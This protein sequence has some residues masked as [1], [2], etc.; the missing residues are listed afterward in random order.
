ML[1]ELSGENAEVAKDVAQHIAAFA[2]QFVT[3][4]EVPSRR[5]RQ[6]ARDRRGDRPRGGQARGA[7]AKIVEGR[8]N[9]FFK[10]TV[11]VEQAFAKDNKK[12][13]GKVLEEAGGRR[14]RASPASRS[15]RPRVRPDPSHN[16][17]RPLPMSNAPEAA[18]PAPG[19]N[20]DGPYSRVLLKL[21]GEA[22][23]GG[24]V[25]LDPDVVADIARQI[26]DVVRTGVQVAIVVGGG[27]FFRGAEI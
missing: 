25:G 27:N 2:P 8:V 9:G 5:R 21:S 22:F 4:D 16:R 11:L 3:R 12:T 13:V 15:A 17:R 18:S 6:G 10:E 20:P 26:A 19:P 1:V 14:A 7:L 23:G 24:E